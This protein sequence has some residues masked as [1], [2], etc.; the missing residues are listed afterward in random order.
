MR[1][2]LNRIEDGRFAVILLEEEQKEIVFPAAHLP[3]GSQV[4]SWFEIVLDG[5]DIISISLDEDSRKAKETEAR[6]LMR[7]LR[8]KNGGSRFKRR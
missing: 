3:E 5:E 4:N 1:G 6:S 7:K 8:R 2:T